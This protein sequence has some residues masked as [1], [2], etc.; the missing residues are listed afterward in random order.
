[1][2]DPYPDPIGDGGVWLK[3]GKK[4]KYL[5]WSITLTHNGYPITVRGVAFKNT[6]KERDSQPDYRM[7]VNDSAPA[8][9]KEPPKTPPPPQP[10]EEED[11][12][13]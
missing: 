6:K 12:P 8:K 3:D 4:G 1:M 11:V 2:A 9:A 7:I 5:S 13:F 10:K